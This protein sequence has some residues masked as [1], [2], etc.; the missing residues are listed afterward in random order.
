MFDKLLILGGTSDTHRFLNSLESDNFIITVATEYGYEQFSKK[1]GK[2]KVLLIKF[3]E[4]SLEKFIKENKIT[5]IIDTTHPYAKVIT[6]TALNVSKKLNIE[7]LSYVRDDDINVD[8]EKAIFFSNIKEVITFL[9]EKDFRRI[10]FTIGS[11]MMKDFAFLKD[12]A[13]V[14]VLP[15]E[16]SIYEVRKYGFDYDKII[17]MQGPFSK[18]F[19]VA[20]IK[21]LKIDLL[22][23]KKSGKAGGFEEKIEACEETGIYCIVIDNE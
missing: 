17:A 18:D 22:I 14:R 16:N 23:T 8:Y 4:A 13:Y 3:D 1:Y 11:K 6:E 15:F 12:K 21:E 10:L 7:Y 20:L 19:N 9:K 5:K 2:D